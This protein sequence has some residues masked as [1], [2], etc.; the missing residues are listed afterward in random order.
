MYVR[1]VL[2]KKCAGQALLHLKASESADQLNELFKQQRPC[3]V[4]NRRYPIY[5]DSQSYDR[6][7]KFRR[8]IRWD[9]QKRIKIKSSVD[10]AFWDEAKSLLQ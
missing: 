5:T 1:D 9:C 8:R 3:K 7:A 10:K 2:G 6:Y 4:S